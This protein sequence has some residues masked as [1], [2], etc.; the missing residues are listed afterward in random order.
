LVIFSALREKEG[1]YIS[2]RRIED[3]EGPV[4][5]PHTEGAV[6]NEGQETCPSQGQENCPSQGLKTC[7]SQG[8]ENCP[9]QGQENCP[10]QLRD[11]RPVPHRDKRTV[12]HRDKKPVPHRDK[13]PVPHRDKKTV[14]HRTRT[15]CQIFSFFAKNDFSH[16]DDG[17]KDDEG[18]FESPTLKIGLSVEGG[19]EGHV[20]KGTLYCVHSG[21]G[22]HSLDTVL[23]LVGGQLSPQ[24]LGQDVR[25]VSC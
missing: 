20:I 2:L 1:R 12:T 19:G 24:L 14:P 8:Q 5:L 7:P 17:G 22:L 25:L 11:K 21:V 3:E 23:G 15:E 16:S 18:R 4:P 13:K 10:S 9:S 6:P